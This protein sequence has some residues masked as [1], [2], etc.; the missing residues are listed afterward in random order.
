MRVR[1]QRGRERWKKE[2]RVMTL[3]RKCEKRLHEVQRSLMTSDHEYRVG[4]RTLIWRLLV[5][6]SSERRAA[7]R[8]NFTWDIGGTRAVTVIDRP[9]VLSQYPHEL[10]TLI[11]DVGLFFI[12]LQNLFFSLQYSFCPITATILSLTLK[13]PWFRRCCTTDANVRAHQLPYR[14]TLNWKHSP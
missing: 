2:K 11:A 12:A 10:Y 13:V 14:H 6:V 3:F 8:H 1:R 4:P 7:V 5:L 9:R